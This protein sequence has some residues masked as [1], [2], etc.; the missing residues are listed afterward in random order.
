MTAYEPSIGLEV[1]PVSFFGAIV[2][3]PKPCISKTCRA[4]ILPQRLPELG[5]TDSEIINSHRPYG[6]ASTRPQFWG[7]NLPLGLAQ[8]NFFDRFWMSDVNSVHIQ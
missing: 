3:F 8:G 7:F 5:T 2:P 4:S 1:S 6:H